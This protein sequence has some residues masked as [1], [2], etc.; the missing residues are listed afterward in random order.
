MPAAVRF[1]FTVAETP[2][3]MLIFLTVRSRQ[4]YWP[5]RLLDGVIFERT[6]TADLEGD[7]LEGLVIW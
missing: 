6:A 5:Q 2:V 4:A 1:S 7:R 3:I